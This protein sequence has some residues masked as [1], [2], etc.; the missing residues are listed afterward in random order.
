MVE[1]RTVAA[2]D[3]ALA[4]ALGVLGFSPS[5]S[6]ITRQEI[7]RFADVRLIL[8]EAGRI[9]ISA[10]PEQTERAWTAVVDARW[11]ARRRSR[12]G[13]TRRLSTGRGPA[14]SSSTRS[15]RARFFEARFA[16]FV[17]PDEAAIERA[18]GPGQHDEAAREAA[19]ARLV[20]EAR[21]ARAGRLA[22]G[23]AAPHERPDLA[24]ARRVDHAALP[25]AVGARAGRGL[26][27]HDAGA[28][29]GG[30]E[31]RGGR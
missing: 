3:I 28:R 20:R 10:E 6:P 2:S 15:S 22:S 27:A 8:D 29:D 21:R 9:G 30:G 26:A 14:G 19:R 18:L 31:R 25:G 4:R 16:A 12:A 5:P 7:E 23:G 24:A 13:S 1:G 17:F 11:A